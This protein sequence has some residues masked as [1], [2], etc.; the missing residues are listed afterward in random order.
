M[1]SPCFVCDEMMNGLGGAEGNVWYQESWDIFLL[2]QRQR[3]DV[4]NPT[5]IYAIRLF[6]E[7]AQGH[8]RKQTEHMALGDLAKCDGISVALA[9]LWKKPYGYNSNL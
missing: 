3:S 8:M 7:Q 6:R 9:N 1:F 2:F 4:L 5:Y